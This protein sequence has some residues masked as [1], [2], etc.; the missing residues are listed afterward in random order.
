[1]KKLMFLLDER[2]APSEAIVL[3]AV[4]LAQM[5]NTSLDILLDEHNR[6]QER[7]YWPDTFS[8]P[9]QDEVSDTPSPIVLALLNELEAKNVRYKIIKLNRKS[10]L[11]QLKSITAKSSDALLIIDSALKRHPL[12]QK[13]AMYDTT[14]LLASAKKWH[15][16]IRFAVAVDPL[17]E[18]AE[19]SQIDK[20]LV[21]HA[22]NWK[23]HIDGIKTS[24]VHS[25]F[26]PPMVVDYRAKIWQIHKE[27]LSDMASNLNIAD[28][29]IDMVPGNPEHSLLTYTSANNID[30]LALGL[31]ARSAATAGWIGS[32]TS[33][34]IDHTPCDLLLVK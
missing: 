32:T 25:C 3:K 31:H 14:V 9:Q 2:H 5:H 27:A 7:W 8:Q 16:T 34:I 13:V 15:R 11:E 23:Q 21:K 12:F 4:L 29:D 19:E 30:V 28:V 18:Q 20:R 1:M 26:V 22:E 6:H 33:G 10:Y 24:Y 17:H